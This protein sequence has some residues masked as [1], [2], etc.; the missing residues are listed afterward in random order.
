MASSTTRE[1][2]VLSRAEVADR[3]ISGSLLFVYRSQVIN[4]T[5]WAPFHPGGSL[6]ILHFVGRD[7]TDEVEAYHP[8]AALERLEK[9]S[10]GTAE[11]DEQVGWKP[12]TPPIALGLI[13][14]P[15][16]VKGH[17]A[18]EGNVSLAQ[19]IL[20]RG[21]SL[22]P[23]SAPIPIVP[24]P[25]LNARDAKTEIITL[26]PGELEPVASDLDAKVEKAR[27][28]AY[29]GLKD[30]LVEAELFERP[31]PLAGYGTDILRY[32]LLGSL[33]FGLYFT[34]SGWMGQMA[35]AVFI[36]LFWHQLTFLVHD[37]GHTEVTGDW[38]WDRV[39]AMTIADWVGGLSA[40]WW[41]DNHNIHHLVTNHPE[42]DPD[43][44]HVPFFA[45]SNK[46]FDSMWSTYYK[47][48]MA[49]DGFS[50]AMV[51][52][53]HRLYY[54]VLSLARFNLYANSYSYLLG[55]KVRHDNFWRYEMAGLTFFWIYFGS[56]LRHLP[57]WKM[58]V[59]Y[60]LVTHIM[61]SPV[62]VQIVLSHFACSTDDLGPTE[63]FPSRQL[64][65]TM[66]VICSE[67]IEFVH[68]GLHLQVTHH[69]FP[70]LPRHNLRP[71][72]LLVKEYCKEQ[73]MMYRE[74]RWIEGNKQ[75][76]G[77]LEDVA[78]QLKFLKT[79]ADKEIS[80]KLK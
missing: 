27:S 39:I 79:V 38:W 24:N 73:D 51:A 43:I 12:L 7:A 58:R 20:Q 54:I 33:G 19:S 26:T 8:P 34:T 23:T 52:M 2:P 41:C 9:L 11:I 47:R 57:S 21:I 75:V 37:A 18:R 78:N 61:A 1:R 31:G 70:R 50:R 63:S 80:E 5:N 36:G 10:I 56:M 28:D 17:W 69:L 65:T 55:P 40:G 77:V 32:T 4:A 44:Q 30:K 46:F 45:I 3:I 74:H 25:N 14:H 22:D 68:G 62:H 13:K 6:A 29:R 48:V 60:V 72:S 42:H 15:D 67:N 35:S 16:G 64:R 53:Q 76:L 71:A 59:A 66:D 49:F